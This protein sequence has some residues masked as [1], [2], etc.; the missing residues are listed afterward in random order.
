MANTNPRVEDR[1]VTLAAFRVMGRLP[2]LLSTRYTYSPSGPGHMTSSS[3]IAPSRASEKN[4][5]TAISPQTRGCP[6]RIGARAAS[7]RNKS[8]KP[9]VLDLP[10]DGPRTGGCEGAARTHGSGTG[11]SPVPAF[12]ASASSAR[13]GAPS[14]AELCSGGTPAPGTE[15]ASALPS[16]HASTCRSASGP[17]TLAPARAFLA[18]G[19][20]ASAASALRFCA[21]LGSAH[22]FPTS[23]RGFRP[24]L[25]VPARSG[26]TE[27]V[28]AD[29]SVPGLGV[30]AATASSTTVTPSRT[31]ALEGGAHPSTGRSTSMAPALAGTSASWRAAVAPPADE[32]PSRAMGVGA[33]GLCASVFTP[34]GFVKKDVRLVCV[35]L[36][37]G[38]ACDT[39]PPSPA[40][41]AVSHGACSA[42]RSVEG[43]EASVSPLGHAAGRGGSC[44]AGGPGSP[45]AVAVDVSVAPVATSDGA[46]SVA[47]SSGTEVFLLLRVHAAV[48]HAGLGSSRS[49][50]I[51]SRCGWPRLRRPM[52]RLASTSTWT[53]MSVTDFFIG[54]SSTRHRKRIC[55]GRRDPIVSRSAMNKSRAVISFGLASVP[56]N[57]QTPGMSARPSCTRCK[58]LSINLTNGSSVSKWSGRSPCEVPA[59]C[60]ALDPSPSSAAWG[61]SRVGGVDGIGAASEV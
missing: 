59:H 28:R 57:S 35:P 31:T 48:G 32:G 55:S 17:P 39:P 45:L 6:T 52:P 14:E 30:A 22:R 1:A 56:K 4:S 29:V 61:A 20:A 46:P 23:R 24:R 50:S 21:R 36:L 58:H 53:R 9:T 7:S 38:T 49:S 26:P 13:H 37:I 18:V 8:C 60:A 51:C 41:C 54:R 2:P 5:S 19:A 40:T 43:A 15:P 10:G 33:E 3:S 16:A 42:T 12:P 25:F 27:F 47:A 11:A 34:F 44:F